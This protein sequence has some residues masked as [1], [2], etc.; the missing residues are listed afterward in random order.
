VKCTLFNTLEGLIDQLLWLK[1]N[2][3]EELLK[4]FKQTLNHCYTYSFDCI[5][6]S[7]NTEILIDP[8]SILWFK[9]LNKFYAD[10][11]CDKFQLARNLNQKNSTS[12]PVS[13][14]ANSNSHNNNSLAAQLNNLNNT[15]AN[16]QNHRVRS[17]LAIVNDPN[18]QLTRQKFLADFNYQLPS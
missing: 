18:Y 15:F 1:V 6:S 9:K 13:G 2:W 11:Y 14:N 8:F 4:I 12:S 16:N 7:N 17:L 10:P 5:K 3:Y